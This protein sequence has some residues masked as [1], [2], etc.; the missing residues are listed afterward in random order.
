V[1]GFVTTGFSIAG[2]LFPMVFAVLLDHGMPTWV[3]ILS[4]LFC[5]LSILTVITVRVRGA[6]PIARSAP[7]E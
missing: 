6:A 2:V 7:A 4:A 5:L 1:F 3:F